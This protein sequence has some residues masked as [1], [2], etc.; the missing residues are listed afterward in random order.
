M[1]AAPARSPATP[2]APAETRH[3]HIH[4]TARE[5]SAWLG[6]GALAPF[7]D[8]IAADEAFKAELEAAV[9]EEPFFRTK[10]WPNLLDLGVYRVTLYALMRLV[11]PECAIE[12]GVLHGLTS[13][14]LCRAAVRNGRGGVVSIDLPSR[15]ETGPA[16]RD[17][18]F[19]TLPRGREPGWIVGP[20]LRQVWDLRLGRSLDELPGVLAERAPIGLFLHDSEHS[21]ETMHGEFTA[22]W[23][24]IADGGLLICD[25][26]GA[27]VAFFD[28]AR[29]VDRPPFVVA[30]PVGGPVRFGI[31]VK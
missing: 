21:Y 25:N 16:N 17:G 9:G 22:V 13:A 6:R 30:D 20:G 1:T 12:T 18:F 28:F 11:A 8:E 10:H 3:A 31:L 26:A 24:S 27:T 29:A 15:F 19:D 23:D 7:V 4:E 14:F 2:A 5:L